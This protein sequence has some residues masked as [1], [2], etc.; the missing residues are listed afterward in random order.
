MPLGLAEHIAG[1]ERSQEVLENIQC[2]Y[3]YINQRL[4]EIRR[5]K[6]DLEDDEIL[7]LTHK[8]QLESEF[9]QQFGIE[10]QL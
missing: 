8:R 4:K 3:G 5:K 1:G 2:A 9:K 7:F 6:A 10:R